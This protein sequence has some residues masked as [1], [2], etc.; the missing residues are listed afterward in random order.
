MGEDDEAGA[1]AAAPYSLPCRYVFM[2][3]Y[4]FHVLPNPGEKRRFYLKPLIVRIWKFERV[5]EARPELARRDRV[6]HSLVLAHDSAPTSY[7]GRKWLE[8]ASTGL[9]SSKILEANHQI[10]LDRNQTVTRS[11]GQ[12][13]P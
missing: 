2:F 10:H 8:K 11:Q 12:L 1:K 5:F 6:S 3:S 4:P 13:R 9:V 7:T